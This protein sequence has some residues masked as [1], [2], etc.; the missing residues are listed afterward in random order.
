MEG[1]QKRIHEHLVEVATK[2]RDGYYGD[3]DDVDFIPLEEDIMEVV[4]SLED[5]E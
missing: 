2:V 4:D 5:E 3:D 1:K